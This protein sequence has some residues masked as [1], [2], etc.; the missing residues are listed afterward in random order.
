MNNQQNVCILEANYYNVYNVHFKL[1]LCTEL[2]NSFVIDQVLS[3]YTEILKKITV[4]NLVIRKK[5]KKFHIILNLSCL[6]GG[7]KTWAHPEYLSTELE[8][9][10]E[11]L[12]TSNMINLLSH[13]RVV[14]FVFCLF[15][16]MNC[17]I[18]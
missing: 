4:F 12:E 6:E 5:C 1:V 16:F 14:F 9:L 18:S 2:R 7:F 10:M 13:I 15:Y 3:L 8:Q 11:N 17:Y